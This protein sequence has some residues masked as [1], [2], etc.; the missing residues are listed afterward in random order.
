MKVINMAEEMWRE[1]MEKTISRLR[2]EKE[3]L[4][5][6]RQNRPENTIANLTAELSRLRAENERLVSV[7][8]MVDAWGNGI[9]HWTT[10]ESMMVKSARAALT[11]GETK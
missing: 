9:R 8:K 4:D 7:A 11:E 10:H 2:L 5:R 1:E 3:E 6:K